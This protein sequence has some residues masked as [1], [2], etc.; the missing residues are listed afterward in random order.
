MKMIIQIVKEFIIMPYFSILFTLVFLCSGSMGMAD[1]Y[2]GDSVVVYSGRAERLIKPVLDHFQEKTGTTVQLLTA[3]STELVNRLR[4]EGSRTLADVY[5]TNDAGA[6]ELARSLHLLQPITLPTVDSTIPTP[7]R[8]PDKSWVGLSG[9]IWMIVYNTTLVDPSTIHSLLDL[10]RPDWKGKLAI[11][12]AN[13]EYLQAGASVVL[14]AKGEKTVD[15][16][17]QGIRDNAGNE[18]YGKNRQIVDAVAKGKV[19]VGIVNHYYIFRHLA[20]DPKA[21]IA[22]LITDQDEGGMGAIMNVA[23]IGLT[24]HSKHVSAANQLIEFLMSPTGQEMFAHINKEYPVNPTVKADPELPPSSTF[25]A[26]SISL[27]RLAE[28]RDPIIQKIQRL[29]LR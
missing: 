22:P 4:A 3:G 8:A 12:S 14:A 24:A 16:F 17:L 27:T 29:G 11:P 15:E 10:A 6:L 19:S 23:G 18:V 20:K 13:S 9:R 21:P 25:R 26:S 28:L 7:F 1:L 5:I 2:A